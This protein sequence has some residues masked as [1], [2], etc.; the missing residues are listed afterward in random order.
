MSV[1]VSYKKQLESLPLIQNIISFI[2]SIPLE[3]GIIAI[4]LFPLTM[5][6]IPFDM[7]MFAI[8]AGQEESKRFEVMWLL[9]FAITIGETIAYLLVYFIAKHHLHKIVGRKGWGSNL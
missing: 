3:Y 4:L 9:I 8:V 5:L 2:G 1:Q 7:P 6:P